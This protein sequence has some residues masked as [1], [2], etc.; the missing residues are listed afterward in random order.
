MAKSLSKKQ[1]K[2]IGDFSLPPSGFMSHSVKGWN[3]V[4]PY[5]TEVPVVLMAHVP[6]SS[7][8]MELGQEWIRDIHLTVDYAMKRRNEVLPPLDDVLLAQV[9]KQTIRAIDV[10][11]SVDSLRAIAKDRPVM[12]KELEA[13]LG[14]SRMSRALEALRTTT[15][16]V[17]LPDAIGKIIRW[18]NQPFKRISGPG[19]QDEFMTG[20]N[21][22]VMR[23][24]QRHPGD[25]IDFLVDVN[26][27]LVG[28]S[29]SLRYLSNILKDIDTYTVYK[30]EAP[31][32]SDVP[33]IKASLG[34]AE[35]VI[36]VN[37][38]PAVPML[39]SLGGDDAT[40]LEVRYVQNPNPDLLDYPYYVAYGGEWRDIY[41]AFG[42][43]TAGDTGEVGNE[44]KILKPYTTHNFRGPEDAAKNLRIGF[45]RG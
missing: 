33:D 8:D 31:Y 18:T 22:E 40:V 37:T 9:F 13:T 17:P 42:D 10:I 26:R 39:T 45:V 2:G 43:V 30:L 6:W 44:W 24:L 12:L 4:T 41:A 5:N 19:L 1:W 16:W 11:Y 35:G 14:T 34:R 20:I 29:N 28:P 27:E 25:L 3:L 36:A 23:L 38:L 32:S 7:L 21:F 15:E